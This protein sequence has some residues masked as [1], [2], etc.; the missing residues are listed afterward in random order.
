M[1]H[2]QQ[3]KTLT[4]STDEVRIVVV[5]DTHSRPHPSLVSQVAEHAPAL[6]LHAGDLGSGPLL[7]DLERLA[8][9]VAVRGNVD[10]RNQGLPDSMDL[11]LERSEQPRLRLLLT[12]IAIYRTHLNRHTRNRAQAAG[13]QLVV[14]GHSHLPFVGRDGRFALYNPGSAGPRRFRLPITF[15]VLELGLQGLDLHHVDLETGN[16]W[17]P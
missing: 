15:G 8:P 12:H 4:L 16:R 6:V 10:P 1:Q 2:V 17:T 7:D 5:A 3:S 14:F 9:V 11:T 13:A